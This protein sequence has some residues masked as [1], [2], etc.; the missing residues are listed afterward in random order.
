MFSH[1]GDV[2][3]VAG[4]GARRSYSGLLADVCCYFFPL[5]CQGHHGPI[6]GSGQTDVAGRSS[7]RANWPR[8]GLGKVPHAVVVLTILVV[9]RSRPTLSCRL[10]PIRHVA[11]E[12]GGDGLR[13]S[14]IR[15]LDKVGARFCE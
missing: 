3:F 6:Q 5:A 2:G 1:D 15:L 4:R 12:E 14:P 13:L 8:S 9:I 10:S 11:I 7:T